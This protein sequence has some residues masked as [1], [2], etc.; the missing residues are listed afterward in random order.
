MKHKVD[1]IG[2][3]IL[4]V[5]IVDVLCILRLSAEAKST[6]TEIQTRKVLPCAAIPT[7]HI[8]QEPERANKLLQ[9]MNMTN[10]RVL[11][12]G[13]LAPGVDG[14]KRVGFANESRQQRMGMV[15]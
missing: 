15:E 11:P 5:S 7:R 1:W 13:S 3:V 9:A 14:Q 12:R 6:I 8:L 4:L 2:L 10:V